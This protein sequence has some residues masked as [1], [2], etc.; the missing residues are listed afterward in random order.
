VY[1]T[2]RAGDYR[3]EITLPAG[4]KLGPLGYTLPPRRAVETPQPQPNVPLLEDLAR[5]TGGSVSPDATALVQP[6]GPP[7]QRP[8]LPYLIPL[9]MTLYFIELLVR[10]VV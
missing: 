4:E 3:V 5:A 8:L 7:E 10:R 9:A 6:A 1:A 2:T